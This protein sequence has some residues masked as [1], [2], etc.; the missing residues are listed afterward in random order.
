MTVDQEI[1]MMRDRLLRAGIPLDNLC[2]LL[3]EDQWLELEQ[4]VNKFN[5]VPM[6]RDLS[7]VDHARFMGIE[8]RK[9]K[10]D[11]LRR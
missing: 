9:R 2:Y 7:Y 8:V 5:L 4:Y 1:M 10:P 11:A 6:Q 3:D